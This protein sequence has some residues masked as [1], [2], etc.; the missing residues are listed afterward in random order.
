MQVKE[1]LAQYAPV[2]L[3]VDLSSLN[4]TQR[5]MIPLL[6]QAAKAMEA[7][8]WK[9]TYGD[10]EALLDPIEDPDLKRCLQIN[11]GPWDRLHGYEPFVE[12]VKSKPL[13]AEFYPPDMTRQEFEQAAGRNPDLKSLS[14][15]V[16]R[17]ENGD[18]IAIPYHQFFQE[19]VQLAAGRLRQAAMLAEDAGLQRYLTLRAEALLTDNY[20]PSDLAWM[21]MK[22]NTIDVV[23]GP[24][25][26]YIDHLFGY[27]AAN[28]ALVLI[29]DKRWG[30]R[31]ARYARL[32]PR[33]QENLPVPDLYRSE[34]PGTDS[35]IGVYDAV[36]Y[37]GD[38]N[39]SIPIAINL[40]NDVEVQLQKGSRSLQL[41]NVIR[42]K[43]EKI[44]VPIANLLIA[45]DQLRHLTFDAF[46]NNVMFHELAHGL[47]VKKTITGKGTVRQAL[48]EQYSVIEESK[49]DILGLYM[50]TK[51]HEWGQMEKTDLRD[52][53]VT[54][55]ASIF[56]S[57]RFGASSAHGRANLM[58]F[59]FFKEMGAL[60]ANSNNGRYRIDFDKAQ[61][62]T[63]ALTQRIVQL[64]GDG[65]YAG[66]VSF[67][68]HYG[69]MDT[70]LKRSLSLLGSMDIPVEIAFEQGLEILGL[71]T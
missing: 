2:P 24:I 38:A 66:V 56:R 48:K 33:L 39:A 16:R 68:E 35:D 3:K 41:K 4:E 20:Q 7:I 30:K 51:L 13:G 5:R 63:N 12:G 22:T 62:A 54:F 9:Q 59:N 53:Y 71:N 70:D 47:G 6:I 25:E 49:A 42:A 57:I 11:Y 52:N 45:E 43:F 15:M 10:R 46:F 18:L 65:D 21:D 14:S 36:Y 32:L 58:R 55:V 26:T 23:I 1:R 29:K 28:E 19:H 34:R 27:K 61:A 64:Q 37:A 40:P 8:F 31:L 50:I 44:L 17:N 60:A 69:Q 67:A